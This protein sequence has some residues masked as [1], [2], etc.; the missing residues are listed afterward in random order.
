MV[1]QSGSRLIPEPRQ[2]A[3]LS[4]PHNCA[5][6][7]DYSSREGCIGCLPQRIT[8]CSACGQ[9]WPIADCPRL[10]RIHM[11]SCEHSL[12]SRFAAVQYGCTLEV[13]AHF[14]SGSRALMSSCITFEWIV[15]FVEAGINQ[16]YCCLF[17]I[18]RPS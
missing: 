17:C 9:V 2:S 13:F 11:Q 5:E 6:P 18:R 4:W 3:F 15:Y 10:R 12:L 1:V 16:F 14:S 8:V 7:G